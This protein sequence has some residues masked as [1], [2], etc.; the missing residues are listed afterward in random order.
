MIRPSG[1]RLPW[2]A[3]FAA[4][5]CALFSPALAA[6]AK[7]PAKRATRPVP[8]EP[9]APGLSVLG[10]TLN[11]TPLARIRRSLG[12]AL[13]QSNGL[14]GP[15]GAS[16]LCY[17]GKDGTRLLF[18]A[19]DIAGAGVASGLQL[20][21]KGELPLWD[22]DERGRG[23]QIS[24]CSQLKQLS[25]ATSLSGNLRLGADRA[26]LRARMGEPAQAPGAASDPRAALDGGAG[27]AEASAPSAARPWSGSLHWFWDRRVPRGLEDAH[28]QSYVSADLRDDRTVALRTGE[29]IS[30]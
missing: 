2:G 12:R 24:N 13:L 28:H 21:A 19:S 30:N 29:A 26:E 15:L 11:R 8:K 4:C 1:P 6:R 25:A 17:E 23:A 3:L 10:V 18:V 22:E 16:F 27:P 9:R 14:S 7:A 20:L 5:A